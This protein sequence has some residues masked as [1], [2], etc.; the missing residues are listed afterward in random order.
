[1]KPY[2]AVAVAFREIQDYWC[3]FD[4]FSLRELSTSVVT[5]WKLNWTYIRMCIVTRAEF[6]SSTAN[7]ASS[8]SGIT[9]TC[10]ARCFGK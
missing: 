8:Q 2:Y 5:T 4:V 7:Y 3:Y 10:S 1:V 9:G 6:E